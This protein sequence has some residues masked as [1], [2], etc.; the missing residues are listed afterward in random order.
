MNNTI[1][2]LKLIADYIQAIAIIFAGIWAYWKFI[3]QR[4]KEPAA[5]ID[6]DVRFVGVQDDKWIIELTSC[7]ENKSFVR[8]SYKKFQ[9]IIRYLT[10]E[11]K[12]VDSLVEKKDATDQEKKDAKEEGNAFVEKINFQLNCPRNI[13]ERISENKRYFANVDY[14]N[15]KQKFKHRYVTF[16]STDASFIWVQCKFKFLNTGNEIKMNSQKI[17]K[18]PA[19]EE[20]QPKSINNN[21]QA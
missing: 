2:I 18:V 11:D 15:P 12:I 4:E 5:D 21:L 8:L 9:V 1:E 17:F 19:K 10:H 3:Y 14:I 13:D 16:I 6:I 7:V 20:E